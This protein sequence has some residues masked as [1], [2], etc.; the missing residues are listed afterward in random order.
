MRVCKQ[1]ETPSDIVPAARG[2]GTLCLMAVVII[3]HR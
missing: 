1:F 3:D 2:P